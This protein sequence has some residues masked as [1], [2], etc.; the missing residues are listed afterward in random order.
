M[1]GGVQGDLTASLVLINLQA[2]SVANELRNYSSLVVGAERRRHVSGWKPEEKAQ[3]ATV[4]TASE[5]Q[6]I[7][8]DGP[9]A[10]TPARRRRRRRC[11]SQMTTPCKM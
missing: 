5:P 9:S 2:A 1:V 3:Q 8:S 11:S 7:K 4:N 6:S 10:V